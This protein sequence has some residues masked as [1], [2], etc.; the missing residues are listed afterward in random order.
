MEDVVRAPELARASGERTQGLLAMLRKLDEAGL[1][2][3]SELPGWT[4]LTIVCHL[5]YGTR[6]LRRMTLDAVA[7]RET[8]YYPQGRARQR[9]TTLLPAPHERPTDVLDDWQSAG[10]KLDRT[11]SSLDDTQWSTEVVEPAENPD[12]G[13][14]HPRMARPCAPHR[15]RC[16]RNRPRHRRTRLE[17][18]ARRSRP[19]RLGWPGSRLGEPIIGRSTDRSVAPGCCTRPDGPRWLVTVEDDLVESFATS[20]R[21][22]RRRWDNRGIEP[23]PVLPP[24]RPTSTYAAALQR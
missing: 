1:E 9:P 18:H 20:V 14:R 10:A 19:S 7:G 12:L 6:A 23:R 13:T 21:A 3:P 5:R 2:G 8:S 16:S 17:L 4:R 22:R 11:W 15:G 24:S